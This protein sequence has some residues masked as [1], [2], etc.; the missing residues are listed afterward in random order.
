MNRLWRQIWIGVWGCL[1]WSGC[2]ETPSVTPY[3]PEKWE[4]IEAYIRKTWPEYTEQNP[5]FPVPYLY[6]LNPGTLYYWDLYFHN[7]GLM[8]HGYWD[9]ARGNLDCMIYQIE[10]LGFI[11]NASGW[12][13]DRS[14]TPCFS[15][16][17]RRYYEEVPEKDTAWL[18]KAYNAVLKEY[19]FWTNT[20]GNAIED[21]STSIPG[22]QRYGHHS[23]S[24]QL[25]EF[26][27]KVLKGRF[28]LSG[29]AA[30]EEKIAV[31]AHRMA[32]AESSMDFTPRFEGRCMDYIP[33][34]LNA[35][36]YG[37]E[38]DLA[39][40]EQEL[41]IRGPI[42]WDKRAAERVELIDRYCWNEE[43]GL[44]LDYDFVHQRFSPVAAM[45]GLMPLHFGFASP[46][47]ADR[48]RRNLSLFD[49][50]G[51][52]VVCEVSPQ[53]IVYQWGDAAVW[54]PIQQ[55]GIESMLRYGFVKEA[56]HIATQWLNTVTRNYLDPQPATHRPFKYGDGTRHPGFLYEKYTRDGQINDYEYPCSVMLGWT[57]SAF[58]VALETVQNNEGR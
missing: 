36:L 54:A 37:Y 8:R 40:Y 41:G 14:Q 51:G 10:K 55:I 29:D 7:E 27:D 9:I 18:R 47:K 24:V 12:G 33:V 43:R 31:A 16:S 48:V 5:D 2:A 39:F 42:N 4:E 11:P 20:N 15:M 49:S 13:E 56:K 17:V 30:P 50:E 19:E 44:Y 57:A 34:D 6:G 22:L 3:H 28:K 46:E 52:L 53:E 23:D 58:L 1:L 21:H 25:V 45:S 35:Y 38:K 32:E 26:Y